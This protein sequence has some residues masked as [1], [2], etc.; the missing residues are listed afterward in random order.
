M[1]VSI[2]DPVFLLG[3][4]RSGTTWLSQIIESAPGFEVRLSPN[5][6]YALKN[7]LNP[8]SSREE[9]LQTLRHAADS[10]DPF[11]TQNW[12]R[13]TGELPRF[14]HTR[15]DRRRLAIK[16]TRFHDLY[17]RGLDLFPR[18]QCVAL[19]RHP[20]GAL[21]SWRDSKEFPEWVPFEAEWRLGGV[22]KSEGPGEYWGF[23][24][25][26]SVTRMFLD[27]QDREPARVSIVRYEDLARKPVSTAETLFGFLG[28]ELAS[29]TRRFIE[30]SQAHH[31]GRTY[32]VFKSPETAD[33]WRRSFPAPI[34]E[35]IEAEL[36]GTGLERFLV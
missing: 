10:D 7:R 9:W 32:S 27:Y 29:S 23:D 30:S 31:D 28:G 13:D 12:R 24:D 25:W 35:E 11:M 15:S 33:A 1:E 3:M 20:C 17:M 22:R 2:E 8:G 26:V 19:V 6:S 5:Y 21:A 14:D 16:D 4:P 36:R 18:A 34:L